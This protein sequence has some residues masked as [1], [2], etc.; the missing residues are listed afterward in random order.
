VTKLL[1]KKL[2]VPGSTAMLSGKAADAGT[3]VGLAA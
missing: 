2:L 3:V 1:T